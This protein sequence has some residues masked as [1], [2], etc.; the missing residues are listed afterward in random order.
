VLKNAIFFGGNSRLRRVSLCAARVFL[1]E[2]SAIIALTVLKERL[3]SETTIPENRGFP[4][5]KRMLISIVM[6]TN[7]RGVDITFLRAS[8]YEPGQPG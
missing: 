2:K 5:K 6:S 7:D 8:S 4:F 1:E 3:F